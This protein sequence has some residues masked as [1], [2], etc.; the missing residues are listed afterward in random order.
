[1]DPAD[2]VDVPVRDHELGDV[3]GLETEERELRLR[4][5]LGAER[6]EAA[7]ESRPSSRPAASASS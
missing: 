4:A 7:E 6:D 2:V 3:V 5:V 1:M